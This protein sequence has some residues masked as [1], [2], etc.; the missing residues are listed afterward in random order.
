MVLGEWWAEAGLPPGVFN[1]V[2]GDK[3]AVDAILWHPDI[4]AGSFVV[5]TPIARYVYENGTKAGKREQ[6]LG[7]AKN[8]MVGRPAAEP[9]QTTES[10]V[11]ARVAPLAIA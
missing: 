8:H 10:S 7:G 6:A 1:V 9:L 5:S 3:V 11:S 2:H 4:K